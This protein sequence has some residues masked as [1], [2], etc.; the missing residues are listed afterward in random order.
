MALIWILL[1][2]G[3]ATALILSTVL[4]LLKNHAIARQIGLPIVIVPISPENPI[5]MMLA[6]HIVPWLKYV[7][8]GNGNFSKFAHVGWE[9]ELKYQAYR[10]F[11]DALLMVSPGKNWI[12]V[13][14]ADTIYD[15]IQRERRHNFE[16]PVEL[17]G[18]HAMRGDKFGSC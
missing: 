17:L 10:E 4:G 14:N 3:P 9:W 2:L 11:G 16:R 8:F 1:L 18:E 13:C 12:Y 6:R 15:V 7:P 5:W